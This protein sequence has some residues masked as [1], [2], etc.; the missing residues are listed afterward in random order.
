MAMSSRSPNPSRADG[1]SRTS[2]VNEASAPT[3]SAAGVLPLA[4]LDAE[5]L[6]RRLL[7]GRAG[8]PT[9]CPASGRPASRLACR[10]CRGVLSSRWRMRGR[11]RCALD[12]VHDAHMASEVQGQCEGPLTIAAHEGLV[13]ERKRGRSPSPE[14]RASVR[15]SL[16]LERHHTVA[17]TG[18]KL[19]QVRH[20]RRLTLENRPFLGSEKSQ[21]LCESNGHSRLL[22]GGE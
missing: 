21:C 19:V 4:L 13:Q 5:R 20:Q 17:D 1:C 10:F 15:P 8:G 3:G 16:P 11:G 18:E 2:A 7:H 22:R 14:V 9:T 6:S 12:L